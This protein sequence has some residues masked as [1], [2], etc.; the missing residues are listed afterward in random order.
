MISFFCFSERAYGLGFRFFPSVG[1]RVWD[2]G[3]RVGFSVQCSSSYQL[4][5]AAGRGLRVRDSALF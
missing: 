2:S 1:F 3:F 4:E 5:S